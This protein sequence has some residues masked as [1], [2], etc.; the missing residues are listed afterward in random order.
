MSL[1]HLILNQWISGTSFLKLLDLR[2]Q[3]SSQNNHASGTHTHNLSSLEICP[4][5]ASRVFYVATNQ[6][7]KCTDCNAHNLF[8]V[9]LDGTIFTL[10]FQRYAYLPPYTNIMHSAMCTPIDALV[11]GK[12]RRRYKFTLCS[13]THLRTRCHTACILYAA[14]Q[15][16]S[17]SPLSPLPRRI[18]NA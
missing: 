18:N 17:L 11:C 4:V 13:C 6:C 12:S 8:N 5:H 9:Y 14:R 10:L 2:C 7:M 3:L 16:F 15:L 1:Q